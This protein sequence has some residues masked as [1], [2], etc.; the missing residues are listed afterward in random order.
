MKKTKILISTLLAAMIL[1]AA[2][3]FPVYADIIYIRGDANSDGK[4]NINDVTYVQRVIAKSEPDSKGVVKRNCD[5]DGNGLNIVDATNIQRY[6]ALF[7]N[8]Y[9]IGKQFHY[10]EYELPFIP[11]H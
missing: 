11:S 7:A 4:V 3:A 8:P 2:A 9:Q 6:I 10:D 5:V 1:I